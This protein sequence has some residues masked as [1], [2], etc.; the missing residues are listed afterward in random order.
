MIILKRLVYL[1]FGSENLYFIISQALY[2]IGLWKLFEKS[3]IHGWWALV[4]WVR[5]YW[6]GRCAWK[7]R[8]GLILGITSFLMSVFG[9]ITVSA[10]HEMG[11]SLFVLFVAI[12]TF[13][14]SIRIYSGLI[15]VYHT[16][17]SW[18]W[19]WIFAEAIPALI[20]GFSRK[21]QPTEDTGYLGRWGTEKNYN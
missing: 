11:F 3:G 15:N 1:F 7:E 16:R 2:F 5:E 10:D 6:L 19:L 4:P 17:K 8:D 13:V 20:W 12:F 21:Y 14:Y 18:L 9:V